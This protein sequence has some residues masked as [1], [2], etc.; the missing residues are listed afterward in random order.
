MPIPD[1]RR[2]TFAR[3]LRTL[4]MRYLTKPFTASLSTNRLSCDFS[5]TRVATFSVVRTL[6]ALSHDVLA[7][8]EFQSRSVDR[9]LMEMAYGDTRILVTEDKDFGWLTFVAHMVSPG[10]I[11]IRFPASARNTLADTVSRLV[12]EFGPALT[13]SF[14]VLRPCDVRISRLPHD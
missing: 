11:L 9:E 8:S 6:C 2:M 3:A 13:G 12:A 1:S 5:L 14:T 7:V 10:V 4:P